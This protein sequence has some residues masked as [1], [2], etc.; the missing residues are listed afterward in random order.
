MCH[1]RLRRSFQKRMSKPA[2]E[3]TVP[4][5]QPVWRS[6]PRLSSSQEP[7]AIAL[8]C[9]LV[10]YRSSLHT[11]VRTQCLGLQRRCRWVAY[12]NGPPV[13]SSF[14]FYTN[15]DHADSGSGGKCFEKHCSYGPI[16]PSSTSVGYHRLGST[17]STTSLHKRIRRCLSTS[18]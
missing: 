16:R 15:C 12:C 3:P 17:T 5:L 10:I 8:A 2:S 14:S 18:T 9:I 7:T 1:L 11:T 13:S 6:C 4:E